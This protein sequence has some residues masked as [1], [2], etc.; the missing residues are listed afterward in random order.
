MG[1]SLNSE[2]FNNRD[3]RHFDRS[4]NSQNL[5]T[6]LSVSTS[7]DLRLS[8]GRGNISSN[9]EPPSYSEVIINDFINQYNVEITQNNSYCNMTKEVVLS[10]E[11]PPPKYE[12]L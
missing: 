1:N 9:D 8:F 2:H 11:A 5:G 7:P 4:E 3:R 6:N 12:D 10:G